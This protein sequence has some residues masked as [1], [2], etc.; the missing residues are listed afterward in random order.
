MDTIWRPEILE[1]IKPK[2]KSVVAAIRSAIEAGELGPGDRLPPVRELGWHLKMTP[3]TVA[4]AYTILTDEGVLNA[5]VGRGTFVASHQARPADGLL[6]IDVSPHNGPKETYRV[7]L[8]SPS[9]PNIGQPEL[10]RRAMMQV[11]QDPPSGLMHYPSRAAQRPARE[12]AVQWLAGTPLGPLVEQDIVLTHGGQSGIGL[13]F[14]AILTGRKPFILIEEL[15]YPGFRRAA[16]LLRAEVVPVPMD[17]DGIIPEALEEAALTHGAQVLCT[18]PEVHNPTVVFTSLARRKQIVAVARKTGMQ[19]IEDDCYRMGAT[20]APTYRMLAPERGWYVSSIAKTLTPALRLGFAIA[21]ENRTADLRRAAEHGFFGLATPLTDMAALLLADPAVHEMT[22]SA[23]DIYATYLACAQRVLSGYDLSVNA[24]VPFMW[25]KLP[26]GWRAGAF[27]Q[28]ADA[29][30]VQI[31]SAEEF[32]ARDGRVPH[33]V[34]LAVNAMVGLTS[35]EQAMVRLRALLD[36][37]PEE[38]GV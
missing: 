19:I 2:Y 23:R 5:E 7:N 25:L 35:F 33:A 26:I 13:T 14:Q 8:F 21:A 37:P 27:C 10:V 16:E 11:A 4:R 12:A 38:I 17:S 31:R 3:G 29:V 6:E 28:A 34:R 24:E 1:G 20:R 22:L 18:S 32:A 30:G 36:S 15:A 9:L